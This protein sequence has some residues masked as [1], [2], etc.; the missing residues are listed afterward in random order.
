MT[1][2]SVKNI[3]FEGFMG[4]S[5]WQHVYE[6]LDSFSYEFTYGKSFLLDSDVGHGGWA[7][8]WIIGCLIN[9]SIGT[10]MRD[11]S[12]YDFNDR[13]REVWC[14]HQSEIKRFGILGNLTVR[15][16][17]IHGLRTDN[18]QYL[19]SEKE[20][21]ER[22]HLTPERY[23]RP[24]SH[25]SGELW[26]ASCAIG[27]AHGRKIFCFPHM[28]YLRP[29]FNEEVYQIQFKELVD[30][31]TEIGAMVLLPAKSSSSTKGLTDFVISI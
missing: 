7:L 31:L 18:N 4:D 10:I 20:I 1:T 8:S 27:V 19:R 5:G 29:D 23:N 26:R 12:L 16:Q 28:Q 24:F 6:K 11:S 14:V 30:L 3:A 9:P 15:S 17:I 2:L 22:F 25:I 21:K 13:K